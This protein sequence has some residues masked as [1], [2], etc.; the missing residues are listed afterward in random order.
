MSHNDHRTGPFLLQWSRVTSCMEA[1]NLSNNEDPFIKQ[2]DLR[3][4]R[5][6]G[7]IM[8]RVQFSIKQSHTLLHK[9]HELA[10]FFTERFLKFRHPQLPPKLFFLFEEER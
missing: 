9:T 6:S 10:L 1:Q 4:E 3:S 7:T 2:T 5:S 8:K